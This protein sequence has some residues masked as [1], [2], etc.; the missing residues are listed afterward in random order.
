MMVDSPCVAP[1]SLKECD[2][3]ECSACAFEYFRINCLQ[4]IDKECYYRL[5]FVSWEDR[6][7]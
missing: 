2:S 3:I 7:K 1:K 5:F 6:N 4:P